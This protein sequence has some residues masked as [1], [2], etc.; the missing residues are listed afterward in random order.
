M[1][2]KYIQQFTLQCKWRVHPRDVKVYK[3]TCLIRT[4]WLIDANLQ[5]GR[6]WT[7]IATQQI[8]PGVILLECYFERPHYILTIL[9]AGNIK[10][11]YLIPAVDKPTPDNQ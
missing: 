7:N 9:T 3:K 4:H 8:N 11:M 10:N 6:V 1:Y 2:N 5:N